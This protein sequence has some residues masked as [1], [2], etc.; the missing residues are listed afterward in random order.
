M[1]NTIGQR[2]TELSLML[3]SLYTAD[4]AG[5]GPAQ[6]IPPPPR[7]VA[8]VSPRLDQTGALKGQCQEIFERWFLASIRFSWSH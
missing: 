1:V 7:F 3:G 6:P 4:Q 5:A 8:R 2:Q